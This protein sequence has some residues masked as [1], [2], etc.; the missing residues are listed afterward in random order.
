MFRWR[1]AE[2]LP[3]RAAA[4]A[5]K[6]P[7]RHGRPRDRRNDRDVDPRGPEDSSTRSRPSAVHEPMSTSGC[8]WRRLVRPLRRADSPN[9]VATIRRTRWRCSDSTGTGSRPSASTTASLNT[10]TEEGV[11]NDPQR[12]DRPPV[13]PLRRGLDTG[14]PTSDLVAGRVPG[15]QLAMV[16]A[17]RRHQRVTASAVRWPQSERLRRLPRRAHWRDHLSHRV[18]F[19]QRA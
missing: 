17:M 18:V 9:A 5:R 11:G 3:Y 1:F 16:E 13:A 2:D 7:L 8:H 12:A 10:S 4:A 15:G 19:G 14:S 6:G